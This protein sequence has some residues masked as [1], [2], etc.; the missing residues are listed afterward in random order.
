MSYESVMKDGAQRFEKALQ[1]LQELLR[2]IRTG[3]ASSA[4]VENIRVDYY[5]TPTPISQMAS[6]SVP[7]PRQIIVK[8]F[9]GSVLKDIGKAIMKSDLGIT[10]QNDG[11][12]L[13][14]TL[15]PLS[16]E[17]RNKYAAKVKQL[18]EEARVSMRNGRRD[19]NKE[20]D[21]M[22]KDGALTQDEAHKLH[23]DIQDEL[24]TYEGKVDDILKKK[25]AEILEV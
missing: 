20:A 8:P 13:R 17:Q 23:K 5:G 19:L 4:L 16:G 25:T 22:L 6:I 18:C 10:P 14:L 9:D 2:T 12:V 15:P 21:Q 3:R 11:K 1:H 7:E 24:K